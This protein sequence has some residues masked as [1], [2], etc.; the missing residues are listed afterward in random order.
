[1]TSAFCSSG[2]VQS[3][4]AHRRVQVTSNSPRGRKFHLALSHMYYTKICPFR[5]G[6]YGAWGQMIHGLRA[7]GRCISNSWADMTC[8][9]NLI[10]ERLI[11]W[12]K[13]SRPNARDPYVL[14]SDINQAANHDKTS[15]STKL[16]YSGVQC[17]CTC[18]HLL[19][20]ICYIIDVENKRASAS[21][22]WFLDM[23]MI[24]MIRHNK[25]LP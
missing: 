22:V 3:T 14:S 8:F 15:S 17:L 19:V 9:I 10:R 6:A 12:C 11:L 16:H 5:A 18:T 7:N 20:K 24:L 4:S 13:A 2:H 1:M 25:W 21:I 23:D